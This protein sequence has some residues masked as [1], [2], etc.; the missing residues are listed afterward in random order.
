MPS[1]QNVFCDLS[2][3]DP[4]SMSAFSNAGEDAIQTTITIDPTHTRSQDIKSFYEVERTANEI[5]EG[6][7]KR[8]RRI[9]TTSKLLPNG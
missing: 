2:A 8:V 7:F 1:S 6:D 4:T 9:P 3:L 5:I